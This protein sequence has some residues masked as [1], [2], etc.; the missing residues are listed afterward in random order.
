[1]GD[2]IINYEV[3]GSS[4]G[5]FIVNAIYNG[6][7]VSSGVV[8]SS[9]FITVDKNLNTIDIIDIQVVA[10]DDITISVTADCPLFEELTIIEVCI[11]SAAEAGKFIHNEYRYTNG[12]FVSP[13][14]SNL[15]TFSSNTTNPLISRY[16]SITGAVGTGGFPPAGSTMRLASNKI[17]FDTFDFDAA[18]DSFRYYRS[19]TLYGNNTTDMTNL[20]SVST[21]ATPIVG[22][23]PY[24]YADF[25]VPSVGQYLYLIWDYRNSLPIELCYSNTTIKDACCGC[26]IPI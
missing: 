16:N 14:Q 18:Q 20:L 15:V 2:S 5:E 12:A 3:P 11:T 17:G 7:T 13:L 10:V 19:N 24:F 4:T 21:E 26:E 25:T 22:S 8:D 9:G 1:V 6:V 23:S